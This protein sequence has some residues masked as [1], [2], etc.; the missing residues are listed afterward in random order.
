MSVLVL[1]VGRSLLPLGH[2]DISVPTSAFGRLDRVRAHR[3]VVAAPVADAG[4]TLAEG[5]EDRV[6]D[7][8]EERSPELKREKCRNVFQ[9]FF[10]AKNVKFL[11]YFN[12]S[13]TLHCKIYDHK[14]NWKANHSFSTSKETFKN[15]F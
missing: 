4:E 5:L 14:H 13:K 7:F 3:G 10:G 11:F 8:T 2:A 1:S 12:K 15:V 6:E 9:I